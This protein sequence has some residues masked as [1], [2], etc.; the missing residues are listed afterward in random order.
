MNE[1]ARARRGATPRTET[2]LDWNATAPLRPEA[3]AA[4]SAMLARCGNPSSVHRWGRAARQAVEGAR[5]AVGALLGVPP[6]GVIFGSGGTEANHLALLG[7]GRQRVLVSAVEHDSVLRAVPEA[8]RIPVDRD[9]VVVLETLDNLLAADPRPALVSV[10]LANNETGVLQPLAAIAAIARAHGALL[11][12]DA[13]QAA[14]KIALDADA[15]GA[16]LVS[17]SAHKLGGPPGIGALVVTDDLELTPLLRGGGQERGRRAGTENLAGIAGF[18][19]AAVAAAEQIVVY[20]RVRALRDALEAGIAAIAPEAVVLGAA[21]PRLPN[22][23]AI[24]MPGVAAETQVIALDLDGVM[25]SAGAAC[26]SGKV[27]PSHVLEAMRV[28]PDLVGSTIRVSLG[29]N[30]SGADVAHFLRAWT[31]LYRRCRGS[32]VGARAA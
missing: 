19:A 18:A 3:A 28:G 24:A 8:E 10:M 6:D 26:S 15:I 4:M 11:H 21:A 16:D 12:C 32:S 2:Y 14:G 13:V 20:D 31:T 27:G 25:V 30:S 17:L 22:T 29:W 1:V 23:A 7:C 5:S 9:G